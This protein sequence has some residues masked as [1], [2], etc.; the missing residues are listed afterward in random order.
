MALYKEKK[1]GLPPT[2]EGIMNEKAALRKPGRD[3][4][5]EFN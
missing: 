2:N 5:L 4:S 3:S 1:K